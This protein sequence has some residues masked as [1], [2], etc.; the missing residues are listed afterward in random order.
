MTG[1]IMNKLI[2]LVVVCLGLAACGGGGQKNDNSTKLKISSDNLRFTI[3]AF[4]PTQVSVSFTGEVINTKEQVY[5]RLLQTPS[6]LIDKNEINLITL[7]KAEFKLTSP[8]QLVSQVGVF[9]VPMQM[10]ACYDPLCEKQVPGSPASITATFEVKVPAAVEFE[11]SL[12]V[13]ATEG[14][15]S[16]EYHGVRFEYP[17]IVESID[18]TVEQGWEWLGANHH[19]SNLPND[20]NLQ[21][22]FGQHQPIGNYSGKVRV[23]VNGVLNY[24]LNV[25]Y[26]VEPEAYVGFDADSLVIISG[27]EDAF[28]QRV[29]DLQGIE[30]VS[31]SISTSSNLLDLSGESGTYT[32][33][34]QLQFKLKEGALPL[35]AGLHRE[36]ISIHSGDNKVSTLDVLIYMPSDA[37]VLATP[38]ASPWNFTIVNTA[39]DREND[40]VYLAAH[41]N[42]RVYVMDVSTQEITSYYQFEQMP[43]SMTI[44]HDKQW[45]F[46]GLQE[47]D[48]SSY[49]WDGDHLGYIA[50][51]DLTSHQLLGQ[52]AV[53]TDPHNLVV[54]DKS[55]LVVSSGSGQWTSIWM[56]DAFS[57]R[58]KDKAAIRQA[59]NLLLHP[60]QAWVFAADTDLSPSDFERFEIKN[61]SISQKDQLPYHGDYP[62]GG[63]IWMI[64][65]GNKIIARDCHLFDINNLLYTGRFNGCSS[66][67]VGDTHDGAN[68]F[69]TANRSYYES[70]TNATLIRLK[71]SDLST[72]VLS[73]FE[74]S[75]SPNII[76][77]YQDG[78]QALIFSSFN[79][80]YSDLPTESR[81]TV[82]PLSSQ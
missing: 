9:D 39:F 17:R 41:D 7:Q 46:V 53:N 47:R 36:T 11:K 29:V 64:D 31:Y 76:S 15:F 37:T 75:N 12:T 38:L 67:V 45:L 70:V 28:D 40:L 24:I 51:I 1:I 25:N 32:P 33:G 8:S 44:S 35:N 52:Y 48:S 50:I 77:L 61:G 3:D 26:L 42:K 56:F 62:I 22:Y 20:N 58:L 5:F 74:L 6:P 80:F 13:K 27:R 79:G 54:T 19:Y 2:G 63:K 43:T 60:N 73:T 14:H 65:S 10:Y 23:V 55:E 81:V 78:N 34:A 30:G 68:L 69:V 59:S 66:L 72:E 16:N 71:E 18:I 4:A 49:Y 21:V 82:I 57:G